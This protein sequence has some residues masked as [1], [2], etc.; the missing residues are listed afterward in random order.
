VQPSIELPPGWQFASALR[1]AQRSGDRV[2][3]A[4]LPL[5]SL[6]DSPLFAGPHHRRV[7][8]D[9]DPRG[10]VHLNVFA[11]SAAALQATDE[12]L[13][14][15]RRMVRE[16]LALFGSRHF[17]EYEFLLAASDH[18]SGIGL[19][20]HESSENGVALGYF[21]D[22]SGTANGR[23]LL[24]HEM[25]HS[26]NGKFRRPADLWTPSYEVPMGSSLLWVYEGLTEYFGIVLAGRSGLWDPDRT[27]Q[28]LAR[29]AA[30]YEHGRAGRAWRNLQD[31]T[32]QP[33]VHYRGR[34]SYESWQRGKDYYTEGVFLWL[35]VDTRLREL[36]RG[37]R[38]LDD[39]ARAFFGVEDGR[40]EPL[41]YTFDDVVAALQQLAPYDWAGMLRERLDG[42]GAHAPLGGLERGGW[43]LAFTDEPSAAVKE[44]ESADGT[45]NFLY[46]LGLAID[47]DG[48]VTEVLW[49]SVAFRAGIGPEMKLV[50]V[51]GKAYSDGRL[52]DA[53]RASQA[54]AK[55]PVELLLRSADTF[56]SVRLDYHDGLRYPQLQRIEGAPDRLSDILKPRTGP[57]RSKP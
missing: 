27:R 42:H 55:Q 4:P 39:F 43:R 33:V 26:W 8:L 12:Q 6:V 37:R 28:N 51:N 50:A 47:A 9:A 1:G 13:E 29:Y 56:R 54:D 31:T 49:D 48:E 14:A 5:E 38:S 44:A 35:D 40:I 22:W 18:F 34:Q 7:T 16:T 19:E 25:T 52:R 57:S 53:I 30:Q 36:T 32:Q 20:H 41:T 15:H 46:S 45:H 10:P 17:R 2:M 23:D 3:F 21:T 24:P 11:D